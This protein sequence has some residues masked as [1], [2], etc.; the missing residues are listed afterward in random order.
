MQQWITKMTIIIICMALL[1]SKKSLHLS[2]KGVNSRYSDFTL[3]NIS[4]QTCESVSEGRRSLPSM[5]INNIALLLQALRELCP[6]KRSPTSRYRYRSL[7]KK[8]FSSGCSIAG[9]SELKLRK[10]LH[11][12]TSVFVCHRAECHPVLLFTQKLP[13]LS[14]P[15][16][17]LRTL[18]TQA[19][20]EKIGLVFVAYFC[21]NCEFVILCGTMVAPVYCGDRKCKFLGLSRPSRRAC[22]CVCTLSRRIALWKPANEVL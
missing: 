16:S 10:R 19:E 1:W 12:K 9:E 3:E 7:R 15:G 17:S 8:S 4:F 13:S 14:S 22:V 5:R 2:S 21:L 18:G 6:L 11:C 20:L